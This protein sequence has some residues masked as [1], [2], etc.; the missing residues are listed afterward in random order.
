MHPVILGRMLTICILVA[1]FGVTLAPP[2]HAYLDPGA[3]SYIFQLLLAAVVGLAFAI[4]GPFS[5]LLSRG[6][7]QAEEAKDD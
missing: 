7:E 3:D 5:R 4:K 2:A 1:L 6:Q